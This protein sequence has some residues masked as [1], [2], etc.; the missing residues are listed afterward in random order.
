[1]EDRLVT[2]TANPRVTITHSIISVTSFEYTSTTTRTR[3]GTRVTFSTTTLT[4]SSVT[5][6]TST[7]AT[8]TVPTPRGFLPIMKDPAN[9]PFP[10]VN[11][12]WKRDAMPDAMPE[13]APAPAPSY[14]KVI[15]CTMTRKTIIPYTSTKT[16][17]WRTVSVRPTVTVTVTGTET[18]RWTE[19]DHTYPPNP[20][21]STSIITGISTVWKTKTSTS[22]STITVYTSTKIVTQPTPTFFA[23]CG[24]DNQAPPPEIRNSW[25]WAGWALVATPSGSLTSYPTNGTEYD[26]CVACHKRPSSQGKCIG[27][28]WRSTHCFWNCE[29]DGCWD[30]CTGGPPPATAATCYLLLGGT[31]GTCRNNKFQFMNAWG[32]HPGVASNGPGCALWKRSN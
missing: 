16:V 29:E 28:F 25:P 1:V 18:W 7:P 2:E 8:Y 9:Q 13:P 20:K 19:T 5:T 10:A 30:D 3:A 22:W 14:P 23:A 26:C 17:G 12:P 27:S 6:W 4:L 15:S 32:E 31:A 21:T 24:P 11:E